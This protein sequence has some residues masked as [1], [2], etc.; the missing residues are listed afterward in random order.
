MAA[1]SLLEWLT[2][3]EW[4]AAYFLGLEALF[5]REV[6]GNLADQV[7][8]GVDRLR[9]AGHRFEHLAPDPA[10][11]L[12]PRP[13]SPMPAHHSTV[14][15]E[16][17]LDLF[18]APSR[19]HRFLAWLA[20]RPRLGIDDRWLRRILSIYESTHDRPA[21]SPAPACPWPHPPDHPD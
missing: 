8:A 10:G 11:N 3:D 9:A 2:P 19:G 18:D 12:V 13:G 14:C 16:I 17:R 15:E 1:R 6:G 5:H 21:D 7:T 20:E 4:N